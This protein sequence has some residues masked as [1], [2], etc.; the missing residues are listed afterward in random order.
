MDLRQS[1]DFNGEYLA[2]FRP[3][4]RTYIFLKWNTPNRIW[5]SNNE[6]FE[7]LTLHRSHHTPVRGYL[8]IVNN[9]LVNFTSDGY[10][11]RN[12]RNQLIP[13][14]NANS[15]LLPASYRRVNM[16][17]EQAEGDAYND[18]RQL[19]SMFEP[20]QEQVPQQAQDPSHSRDET[21]PRRIACIIAEDAAK[22]NETCG[23]TMEK[24][25]PENSSVTSCFH[26]F[27]TS[28]INRWLQTHTTCPLCNR[29]CSATKV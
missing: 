27:E 24:I 16:T 17:A 8:N 23:I 29:E 10:F 26:V 11:L 20:Q 25:V 5:D 18:N 13:I 15:S 3:R 7:N 14:V 28:A 4:R 21:L 2:V 9:G 22:N 1:G 19:W 6:M 12:M